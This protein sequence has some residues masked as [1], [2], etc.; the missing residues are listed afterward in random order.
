M[1]TS[2][3]LSIDG[4]NISLEQSLGY[5]RTA[6]K[7][8]TV[9]KEIAQQYILEEQIKALGI[10][11]PKEDLVEQFILEF[12][13]QQQLISA[14]SFQQWLVTNGVSYADF[15]DQ[16]I[17]RIKQEQLKEKVVATKV[18]EYFLQNKENL[19]R[20]V[21]SRIVV[22]HPEVAQDFKEQVEQ[23]GADFTELAKKHSMVD[24][25]IVGGVM[26]AMIRAQ[27]PEFI[28]EATKNVQ[29]G[30]I[31][32]PLKIDGRYCLLKVEQLL[33]ASLEG[34][35]KRDLETHLFE[36]WLKQSLQNLDIKLNY[37]V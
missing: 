26:G 33:P 8:S 34:A 29:P 5:L 22:D 9:I 17:F 30:Q 37:N 23:H 19:D 27:M 24:D 25:A 20:V 1:E 31:I 14:E 15:K 6:A 32:G 3:F 35:L 11:E 28:R 16:V 36:E 7:L 21:L 13:M 12:R 4:K 18:E 2:N 10:E